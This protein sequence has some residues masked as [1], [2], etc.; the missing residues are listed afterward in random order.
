MV[1]VTTHEDLYYRAT[2]LGRVRISALEKHLSSN[3]LEI[4][5]S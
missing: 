1:V 2:T 5:D 4:A 3:F